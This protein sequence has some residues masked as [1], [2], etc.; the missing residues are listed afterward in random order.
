MAFQ[1]S[2]T[3]FFLKTGIDE[4]NKVKFDTQQEM[5]TVFNSAQFLLGTMTNCSFQRGDGYNTVRV[6]H[7]AMP[8]YRLMKC[9][10]IMYM[11]LDTD[12][13]FYI[14][15]NVISVEWK[16]P[17]C[18][19]LRFKIDYFMTYQNMIDWSRTYAYIEREHVKNDWAS[20]GGNPLFSN[21]GPA[22]NF[23][24]VADVPFYIW[25]KNFDVDKVVIMSPYDS[26]GEPV[27]DGTDRGG[28]YTSLQISVL[29]PE[30]AN[31]R[32]R[33]IAEKKTA[34]INNI[35][36][37]YGCPSEWQRAISGGGM[38]YGFG[39]GGDISEDIPAVNVAAK[40]LP[41]MIEY[42]NAKCWSSPFVNIR[43][44]SSDGEEVDITPQWLGN[45]QNDYTVRMR[46]SSA[47]G[48]FGGAQ[49]TL[50][51]KN[52]AFKWEGWNDFI[53]SL[54]QLP[55]CPWTG[56]GFTDWQSVNGDSVRTNRANTVVKAGRDLLTGAI[57]A[58]A[59]VAGGDP[60]TA[61]SGLNQMAGAYTDAAT[62]LSNIEASI[63][64]QQASG[65]TVKG[66][67]SFSSLMDIAAKKWGF[68]IVYYSTQI[69]TMRAVDAYFDRFGYRLN[70]MKKLEL[71][72]RPYWTFIKTLEC[73]VVPGTGLTY[74]AERAINAMF[75]RGVTMWT[76]D[77]Y[78]AG[79][80]I[81]DF[82]NPQ[83]NKGIQGA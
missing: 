66:A 72:N 52:G 83:E 28:L 2:T 12:E 17:D 11:N 39:G 67:G 13:A 78:V 47:G 35:V 45:D 33:A 65:A 7:S 4:N 40:Q 73:H 50:M 74:T 9:D 79:R 76:K 43:L 3:V 70:Q 81:G 77:K 41:S 14:I 59:G 51:N 69:Y 56:D 54:S 62:Q 25:T 36:G 6:D 26:S 23:G 49:A 42:N 27:F 63:R 24:T 31:E 61:L 15:G 16:N 21:M 32:F 34:S 18:S 38:A 22:E 29:S 1:P 37:V 68:K 30:E 75:N 20:E 64:N 57:Y 48:L 55:N 46:A 10:T 53:V 58:G 8:Y 60:Q 44:M 19:F 80:K 82:S 71:E 5:Y